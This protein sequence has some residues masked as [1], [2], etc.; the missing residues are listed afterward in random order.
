[1]VNGSP[2]EIIAMDLNTGLEALGKITGETTNEE[3]LEKIF[4]EFCLG[5]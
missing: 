5:K 4:S 1:M 2:M 3:I